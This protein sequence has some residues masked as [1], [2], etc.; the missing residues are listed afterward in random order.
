MILS[1]RTRPTLLE[2]YAGACAPR[3]AFGEGFDAWLEGAAAAANASGADAEAREVAATLPRAPAGSRVDR[4]EF[5]AYE[6]TKIKLHFSHF[7]ICEDD[8]ETC[9]REPPH[10]CEWFAE[11]GGASG[12]G[13]PSAS[14]GGAD[15][16]EL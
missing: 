8:R 6:D 2:A 3:A 10:Q 14:G 12:E 5:L 7:K 13:A 4:A 1:E 15:V 16:G 11:G 9:F